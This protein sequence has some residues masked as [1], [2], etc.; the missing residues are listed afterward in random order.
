MENMWGVKYEWF[1]WFVFKT[2]C[3]INSWCILNAFYRTKFIN[4]FETDPAHHSSSPVFIWNPML[5]FIGVL[6]KLIS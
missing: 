2:W 4:Y 5:R 6:L 3:F 1:L